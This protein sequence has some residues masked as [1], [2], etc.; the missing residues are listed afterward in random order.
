MEDVRLIVDIVIALGAATVGGLIAQRLGLPALIGYILAGLAIGPN[1]PG[2]VADLDRVQLL[3]NLGVALLMFGLGVEFSLSEVIRVRR[4]ALLGGAIQIPLTVVLGTAAGLAGGW[5]L[6]SALLLGGAFA[7]SSSIVALKTLMGRGEMESPHARVALGLGIVQDFSLAPMLALVPV[8][9]AQSGEGL[10]IAQS[11]LISAVVLI[12][13]FLL[14]TR[15]VPPLL[16]VV[17]RAGSRELFMLAIVAIALGVALAT[18]AAG[19]SLGLGAFL[20]GIVVSESEFEEQVLADIIP[21]RDIFA[22]LFFVAVGMLIDP[23]ALIAQWQLV[24]GFA[25]VL[26]IGKLL[27]IGGALLAAGVDHRTAT[28]AAVFMAQMGEFSFV[29][30]SSGFEHG[31]IDIGKYGTILSVALCSILAMPIL[32]A[33]SPWL[34]R[35]AEH[36]PGVQRQERLAAGPPPPVAPAGEHVVICGFGR[37]GAE[38]GAALDRWDQPYSVIELNPAI[39]R[40]L[41]SRGIDALYGDAA[42][43]AELESAGV[44][45]AR[46]VAVTTPDLLATEAVIRNA[47]ALNPAIHVIVRAPGTG[48]VGGLSARGADEVVQPEFEAGLE[49]VRQV[50]G[51]QGIASLQTDD[52]VSARRQTVYGTKESDAALERDGESNSQEAT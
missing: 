24:L 23:F 12:V 26:V 15:L 41:R 48:D 18:H 25:L 2:L 13:A 42:S 19:L 27:I 4:A 22:T 47:R 51:W 14:G 37:V 45:T 5:T 50:L 21:I 11:L 16:R 17:A 10:S 3:A 40:D 38:I 29:L 34:V 7:I 44:P 31:L 1:T 28:L 43:R 33:I 49:F 6:G 39:V 36:L 46:T 20:A 30:A 52:L 8:I 35:I 32:V 9:A